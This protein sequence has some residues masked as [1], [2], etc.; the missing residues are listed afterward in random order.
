MKIEIVQIDNEEKKGY[1]FA[2]EEFLKTIKFEKNGK[3]YY[4]LPFKYTR[5]S[6]IDKEQL[7]ELIDQKKSRKEMCEILNCDL[8]KLSNVMN[9]HFPKNNTKLDKKRV[10]ELIL[11]N[12]NKNEICEELGC[13]LIK[14]NNFLQRNYVSIKLA[15]VIEKLK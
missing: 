12:K 13:D 4:L 11:A 5:D 1:V 3:V 10:E 9:K 8:A 6:K 7:R 2:E 14:L 15:N